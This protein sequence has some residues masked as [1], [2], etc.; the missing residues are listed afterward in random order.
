MLCIH[1]LN[2]NT[3]R[4]AWLFHCC[5]NNETLSSTPEQIV[6][7]VTQNVT[8]Y[9]VIPTAGGYTL[10]RIGCHP[11]GLP[12]KLRKHGCGLILYDTYLSWRGYFHQLWC[13][14]ISLECPDKKNQQQAEQ[15]FASLHLTKSE[16]PRLMRAVLQIVGKHTDWRSVL[17]V[18]TSKIGVR[19]ETNYYLSPCN[20]CLS[21]TSCL[22]LRDGW[23]QWT[24]QCHILFIL[25]WITGNYRFEKCWLQM[26]ETLV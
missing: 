13:S 12:S 4:S 14:F 23:R 1:T 24:R 3:S 17:G 20:Y 11:S 19:E 5:H 21:V 26:I 2:P 9:L 10:T 22:P 16:R 15:T 7:D 25:Y 6:F 8:P 18:Y